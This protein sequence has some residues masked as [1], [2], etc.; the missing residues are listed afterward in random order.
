MAL[1]K[2]EMQYAGVKLEAYS[3]SISLISPN[4]VLRKGKHTD[5]DNL[6]LILEYTAFNLC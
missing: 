3:L 4:E 1:I 2:G 6:K 5:K